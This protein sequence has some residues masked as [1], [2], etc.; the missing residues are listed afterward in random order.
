ML[1]LKLAL[2][3]AHTGQMLLAA[4]CPKAI[5]VATAGMESPQCYAQHRVRMSALVIFERWPCVNQYP[6]V[7]QCHI[8]HKRALTVFPQ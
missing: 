1:Q 4:R 2:N 7:A 8:P 6:A 3:T 5:Q